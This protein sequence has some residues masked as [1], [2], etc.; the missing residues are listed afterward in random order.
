MLEPSF[1]VLLDLNLSV[2]FEHNILLLPPFL[3]AIG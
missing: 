3:K 1:Q 2:L